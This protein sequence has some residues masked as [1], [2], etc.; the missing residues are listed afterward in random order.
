VF[1]RS[2]EYIFSETA[3]ELFTTVVVPRERTKN[4]PG[5]ISSPEENIIFIF[6]EVFKSSH[7]ERSTAFVEIFFSSIHSAEDDDG[8]P[9]HAISFKIIFPIVEEVT[10]GNEHGGGDTARPDGTTAIAGAGASLEISTE[11]P[12][13]TD[14]TS[15]SDTGPAFIGSFS[16]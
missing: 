9:I 4:P 14:V 8:I 6:P 16:C 11:V 13:A 12:S 15:C 5:E 10:P 3:V 2:P 1:A 7:P